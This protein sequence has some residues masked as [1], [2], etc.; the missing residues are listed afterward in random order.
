MA[1]L[2]AI[3]FCR[4][5]IYIGHTSGHLKNKIS[6]VLHCCIIIATDF[7]VRLLLHHTYCSGLNPK[8]R[9]VRSSQNRLTNKH[10]GVQFFH[11][12][13]LVPSNQSPFCL[14]FK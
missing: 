11:S 14:D 2:S 12:D 4:L 6:D 8:M 9:K 7:E 5:P 13:K 3:A 10:V 1:G